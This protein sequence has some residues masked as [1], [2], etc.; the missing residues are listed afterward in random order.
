[1]QDPYAILP[2]DTYPF[3]FNSRL[4]PSESA[5]RRALCFSV[6]LFPLLTSVM[7]SIILLCEKTRTLWPSLRSCFCRAQEAIE[8]Q[9][10]PS[11]RGSCGV[12]NWL[13]II[14]DGNSCGAGSVTA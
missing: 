2:P 7:S 5:C 3:P 13:G 9:E 12:V 8:G 1:M 4:N 11:R 10:D 6:R 14:R